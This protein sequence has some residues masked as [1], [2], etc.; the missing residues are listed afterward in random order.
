MFKS[1]AKWFNKQKW[2]T[3]L[4]VV[5]VS[6]LIA[7]QLLSQSIY[8]GGWEVQTEITS[9]TVNN[10][11]YSEDNLPEQMIGSWGAKDVTFDV[12]A[13]QEGTP[14]VHF[15][16]E[17]PGEY[18]FDRGG[19][20]RAGAGE[21]YDTVNQKIGDKSYHWDYHI[22]MYNVRFECWADN[23]LAGVVTYGESKGLVTATKVYA[24]GRWYF[25]TAP[26][27]N[28][29]AAEYT[30]GNSTYELDE[31]T[32]WAGVM[33]AEIV[34][35]SAYADQ[36]L[37]GGH[38]VH[39]ISGGAGS[40]IN[41]FASETSTSEIT[42]KTWNPNNPSPSIPGVPEDIW[43]ELSAEMHPGYEYSGWGGS[44]VVSNKVIVEYR[45]RVDVLTTAGYDLIEGDGED[46][47]EAGH[48][49]ETYFDFFGWLGSLF[50][51]PLQ[52]ILIYAAI[53]LVVLWLIK[54]VIF[55]SGKK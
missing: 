39:A 4:V 16:V 49:E 29:I 45:V 1:I 9:V 6:M 14:N 18:V 38:T 51:L 44:Q 7:G 33:A 41:M 13:P 53:A 37:A 36:E 31:N 54:R 17:S 48:R 26:W 22:F 43:L 10:V 30:A 5:V 19:W 20:R 47:D 55:R 2:Y 21:V 35:S 34:E 42:H 28:V 15:H 12:D 40:E 8:A 27:A 32:I 52:N 46:D 3:K 23:Q 25:E 50:M 11:I 24:T